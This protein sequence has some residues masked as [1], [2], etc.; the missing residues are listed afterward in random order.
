ME[1]FLLLYHLGVAPI[2]IAVAYCIDG[3]IAVF[4][5]STATHITAARNRIFVLLA[6]T[7]GLAEGTPRSSRNRHVRATATSPA[8]HSTELVCRTIRIQPA[9]WVDPRP[10]GN[11]I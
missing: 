1:S 3:L 10:V 2:T 6:L 11:G 8:L 5:S 7:A 4:A 9:Y